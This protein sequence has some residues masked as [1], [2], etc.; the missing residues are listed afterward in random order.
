MLFTGVLPGNRSSPNGL[1]PNHSL[2]KRAARFAGCAGFRVSFGV[3]IDGQRYEIIACST[4]ACWRQASRERVPG[5]A[6]A[7]VGAL[8]EHRQ[9]T[10]A[11][12]T[13]GDRRGAGVERQ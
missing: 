13:V 9:P 6:L 12:A 10:L 2:M 4:G 1:C 5:R 11:A 8:D 3:L 7:P